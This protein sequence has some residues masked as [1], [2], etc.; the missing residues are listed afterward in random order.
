MIL[1]RPPGSRGKGEQV[2]VSQRANYFHKTGSVNFVVLRFFFQRRIQNV[3]NCYIGPLQLLYGIYIWL[4]NHWPLQTSI[5]SNPMISK[6]VNKILKKE[7][8]SENTTVILFQERTFGLGKIDFPVVF[9]FIDALGHN[10]KTRVPFEKNKLRRFIIKSESARLQNFARKE[11]LA[12]KKKIFVSTVDR[13]AYGLENSYVIPN[14]VEQVKFF[15]F[16][17]KKFDFVFSGNFNYKPNIDAIKWFLKNVWLDPNIKKLTMSIYLVG[18][19]S[20]RF[21]DE[22]LNIY[23]SGEVSSVAKHLAMAKVAI[24]PMVSGSGMQN[25]ILEALSV[26]LPVIASDISLKPME[27]VF[28]VSNYIICAN[29]PD[30]WKRLIQN[31]LNFENLEDSQF[32][33]KTYGEAAIKSYY[34]NAFG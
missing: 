18:I 10:Y 28:G 19:G 8:F 24:C 20:E 5:F 11:L 22:K 26:G 33:E 6:K 14:Y 31:S 25:K 3:V 7:F 29:N 23:A 9:E 16:V 4:F 17:E 27:S 34:E 30:D 12:S 21:A 2:V 13:D 1:T 32:I 15:D